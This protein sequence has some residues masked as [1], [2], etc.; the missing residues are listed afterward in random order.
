MKPLKSSSSKEELASMVEYG[1]LVKQTS[2]PSINSKF[3]TVALQKNGS[4]GNGSIRKDLHNIILLIFLYTLQGIPLGLTASLPFILSERQVA[5]S[6]QAIFSLASWP[7]SLKL[8][9]APVVDSIFIKSIGRRKSWLVPIQYLIGLFM[10]SLAGYLHQMIETK[11]IY[12]KSG[13]L[14]FQIMM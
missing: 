12:L 11:V 10:L 1:K 4:G 14:L 5:Y 3:E 13:K 8:L 6:D 7:F 9:W 2:N